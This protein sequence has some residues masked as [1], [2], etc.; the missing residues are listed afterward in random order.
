MA[1]EEKPYRVYRGGR[2][3]GKVPAPARPERASRRPAD[4]D[5]RRYRGP[6]GG[7]AARPRRRRRWILIG[8]VVFFPLVLVWRVTGFLASRGGGGAANERLDANAKLALN[9]QSGMLPPPPPTTL[10]LATAPAQV[11]GGGGDRHSD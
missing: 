7:R 4:G 3:K 2:T 8:V 11:G 1:G 10:L 6:S 5:A 9:A